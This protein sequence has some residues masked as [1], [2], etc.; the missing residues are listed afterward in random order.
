MTFVVNALSRI[1]LEIWALVISHMTS[2]IGLAIIVG[3]RR[4]LYVTEMVVVV[5]THV[6]H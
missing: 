5:D 2:V 6:G 1:K 4:L 3:D